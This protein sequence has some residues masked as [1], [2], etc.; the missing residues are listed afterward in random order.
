MPELHK[1]CPRCAGKVYHSSLKCYNCGYEYP[2]PAVADLGPT[3][4]RYPAEEKALAGDT[5]VWTL[6]VL[7]LRY[8]NDQHG[9]SSFDRDTE[10][11]GLHGYV[12]VT[13][14]EDGGHIHAGRL[15]F[16]GGLSIFAGKAG[17]RSDGMISVTFQRSAAAAVAPVGSDITA[18]LEKLGQLRDSGVLTQ[19]EFDVKKAELLARL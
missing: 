10:V 8:K 19:T 9:R 17:I 14:S 3:L 15:L 18:L 4:S 13:Q 7:S 16:T 1:A 6:P 12:P 2:K 5:N 11:L